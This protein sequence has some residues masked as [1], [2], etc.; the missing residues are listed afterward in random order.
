SSTV[1]IVFVIF[2]TFLMRSGGGQAFT[3]ISFAAVGDKVGGPALAGVGASALMGTITGNGASNAA[4]TGS[5]TI[6][7]MKRMGYKAKFAAA[8]EAVASQGG[9]I[10]P[11]IMGASVFIMAETIGIPYSKIALYALVPAIL[12]FLI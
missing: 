11:P 8:V 9:Q 2:G 5:F 7:L 12:Y 10:M 1:L 4:F 3:N 6:P